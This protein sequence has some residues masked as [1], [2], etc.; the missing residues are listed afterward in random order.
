M[1]SRV[2]AILRAG[3]KPP[4][5][6]PGDVVVD[7]TSELLGQLVHNFIQDSGNPDEAVEY[8]LGLIVSSDPAHRWIERDGKTF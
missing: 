1:D 4:D 2:L 7:E 5:A 8:L 6:K 3:V